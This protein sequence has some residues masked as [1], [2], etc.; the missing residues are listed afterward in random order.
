M[1]PQFT[2]YDRDYPQLTN[3]SHNLFNEININDF[4]YCVELNIYN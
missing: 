2:Q 1:Y 4:F 3:G